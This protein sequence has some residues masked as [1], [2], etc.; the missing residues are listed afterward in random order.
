MRDV[1]NNGV[2]RMLQQV[3]WSYGRM[4]GWSYFEQAAKSQAGE[5]DVKKATDKGDE[6]DKDYHSN[7]MYTFN[8]DEETAGKKVNT[9][10]ATYGLFLKNL[11]QDLEEED[12]TLLPHL[13]TKENWATWK[14]MMIKMIP[15]MEEYSMVLAKYMYCMLN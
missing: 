2:V 8:K 9:T 5:E 10:K 12:D 1:D 4:E 14:T 6:K 15:H 11:F 3:A 7:F 13:E